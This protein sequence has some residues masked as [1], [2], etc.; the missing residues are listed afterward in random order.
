[1]RDQRQARS[2]LI[3]TALFSSMGLAHNVGGVIPH[4]TLWAIVLWISTYFFLSNLDLKRLSN[5]GLAALVL[6]FQ[7]LGHLVLSTD[8]SSS[9]LR[10]SAAH[11]LTGIITFAVIRYGLF[12]LQLLE[13]GL[14]RLIP[15]SFSSGEVA[16][17]FKNALIQKLNFAF[18]IVFSRRTNQLRAPPVFR[19]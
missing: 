18:L 11:F 7:F 1:M 17:E 2:A 16:R 6:L 3:S 5:A 19:G 14:S 8:T 15:T 12:A 9:G 10:M 13:R 4:F